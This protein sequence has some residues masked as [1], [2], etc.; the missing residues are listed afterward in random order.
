VLPASGVHGR[1]QG[2]LGQGLVR[3]LKTLP[4]LTAAT[5]AV[6]SAYPVSMMRT[7]SGRFSLAFSRKATPSMPGM[8][9][10]ETTTANRR[11]SPSMS[12]P[13]AGPGAVSARYFL[14]KM[15]R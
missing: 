3:K 10:S 5:A 6:T 7:V 11:P 8:R 1:L 12:S 14:R 4:A 13:S 9:K 15:R 2:L